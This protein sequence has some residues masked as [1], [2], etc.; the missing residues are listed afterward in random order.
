MLIYKIKKYILKKAEEEK[1]KRSYE[2]GGH[3][4]DFG[5]SIKNSTSCVDNIIN[6]EK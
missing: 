3:F 5:Q 2:H 4:I 1:R 6:N